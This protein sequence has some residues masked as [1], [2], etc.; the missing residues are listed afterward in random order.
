MAVNRTGRVVRVDEPDETV[1]RPDEGCGRARVSAASSTRPH[2]LPDHGGGNPLYP[3]VPGIIA[4]YVAVCCWR[5]GGRFQCEAKEVGM[6]RNP[7][8]T[9]SEP[10]TKGDNRKGSLTARKRPEVE[11]GSVDELVRV[12]AL[13]LRY[14]DVP[15]GVL[16]HDMVKAGWGPTRIADL[17]GTTP[18]TVNQQRRAK[19]PKWPK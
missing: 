19:R 14:S 5:Y 11:A 4:G 6:P 13:T 7:A 17:L 3:G 1:S 18:N 10:A 2:A 12:I 16:I 9:K 15:Q 8:A